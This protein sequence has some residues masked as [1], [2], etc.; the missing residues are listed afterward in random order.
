M[1]EREEAMN[2]PKFSTELLSLH[3]ALHEP[4]Q[5]V[6]APSTLSKLPKEEFML[7]K[8]MQEREYPNFSPICAAE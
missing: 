8:I 2:A 4:N 7:V 6:T 5:T 3:A 1:A